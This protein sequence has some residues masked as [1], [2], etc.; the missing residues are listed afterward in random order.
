MNRRAF[1]FAFLLSLAVLQACSQGT[2]SGPGGATDAAKVPRKDRIGVYDAV[3]GSFFLKSGA[4]T[5][6][7][8]GYGPPG[9]KPLGGDWDGDGIGTVGIYYAELGVFAVKNANTAGVADRE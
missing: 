2:G 4:G 5:T 6:I 7:Q 9:V 1:R 3:T 8:L